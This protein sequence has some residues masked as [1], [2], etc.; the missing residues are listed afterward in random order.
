MWIENWDDGAQYSLTNTIVN[1]YDTTGARP[2][3]TSRDVNGAW[4]PALNPF[5]DSYY[6]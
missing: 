6:T 4:T 3:L 2:T 1:Y 5:V